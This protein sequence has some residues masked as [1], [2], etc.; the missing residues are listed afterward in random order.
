MKKFRFRFRLF[1]ADEYQPLRVVPLLL[2]ALLFSAMAVQVAFVK[3]VLPPPEAK[4][5]AL[6]P[7]PSEEILR[8]SSFGDE[9]VFARMLM[10]NL[11]GY[12]NQ[13]GVSVPFRKLDYDVIGEWLD[14]IVKLDER[15]DYPHFSAAKLYGVVNH[16]PRRR[17]MIE[18]V[19]KHF[20]DRPDGRW[21]W[22]AFS[23][24]LANYTL[25]DEE[26]GLEMARDLRQKTTPGAVP[27]W[28]RQMEIW[29]IENTGDD[30]TAADMLRQQLLDGEVME[31]LDYNFSYDRLNEILTRMAERGE[32]NDSERQLILGEVEEL[33]FD[34][35]QK[36]DKKG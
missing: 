13:R 34:Q 7:P 4:A 35:A 24:N 16:E 19:R 14:R 26:L 33:G 2:W 27:L 1:V 9:P 31:Q 3:W 12:D 29:F 28:P 8:W 36:K 15:A 18:W 32:I 20:A 10:L 17:K 25:K 6:R 11:Q 30:K 5:E 23:T 21:E 22:M